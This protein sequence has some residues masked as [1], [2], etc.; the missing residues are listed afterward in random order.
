MNRRELL[1]GTIAVAASSYLFPN[2]SFAGP[3]RRTYKES[4][5]FSAVELPEGAET[6]LS[7]FI[8]P[9]RIEMT[10]AAFF[11]EAGQPFN[12]EELPEMSV[13]VDKV[14]PGPETKS[15]EQWEHHYIRQIA[16]R[17]TYERTK[18]GKFI[19]LEEGHEFNGTSPY[20]EFFMIQRA[21]TKI[22]KKTRRGCGTDL[23]MNSFTYDRL[24]MKTR[25]SDFQY[26]ERY[27]IHIDDYLMKNDDEIF[28]FYAANRFDVPG[29][30]FSDG[31]M[32]WN[33]A[34]GTDYGSY[35]T[36]DVQCGDY[37][38]LLKLPEISD[39]LPKA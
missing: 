1:G 13:T 6:G 14:L 2:V 10:P 23:L 31:K 28:V 9:C 33:N 20:Y 24:R 12:S 27:K 36:M 22:A 15:V 25:L 3:P 32:A 8:R 4:Y 34:K 5:I 29:Q 11:N 30:I 21:A 37:G 18:E 39:E 16:N 38:V 7:Y 19:C 26:L 35:R 17:Q